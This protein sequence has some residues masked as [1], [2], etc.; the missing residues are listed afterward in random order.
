MVK[1]SLYLISGIKHYPAYIGDSAEETVNVL[2]PGDGPEDVKLSLQ[3]KHPDWIDEVKSVQ[4]LYYVHEGCK[5]DTNGKWYVVDG[6]QAGE[7]Y[8]LN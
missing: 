7:M 1:T 6:I 8:I 5:Q 4:L 3:T 2:V